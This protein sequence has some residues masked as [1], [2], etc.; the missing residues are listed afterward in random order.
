MT[1]LA[2]R[3][4]ALRYGPRQVLYEVDLTVAAG[5]FIGL[6]GPNGAGKTSLI[7]ALAGLAK[8]ERGELTLDGVRLASLRPCD[9]ARRIAYL[10]QSGEC[11]W[12]LSIADVVGLGRLPHRAAWAQPDP[13][14]AAVIREAMEACGLLDLAHR[15]IDTVSGGERARAM[16]ARALAVEPQALLADEPVAGLDPRH[17]L[18]VMEVLA[19]RTAAG[20]ATVAVFHDLGLAARYCHRLVLMKD[21]RVMADG[22]PEAVLTPSNLAQAFGMPMAV[23]KIAGWPVV[24]PSY[25]AGAEP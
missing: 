24:V 12:S 2:A 6:V 20:Q 9:R 22:S 18:Q 5:E 25:A 4:L 3:G 15:S 14:D 11:A 23:R 7:R 10:P 21:G 1:V 13:R 19:R 8:P 16:L 17:Q